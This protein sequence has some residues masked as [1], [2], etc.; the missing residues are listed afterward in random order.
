MPYCTARGT[1]LGPV[2]DNF[3]A[4]CHQM[5]RADLMLADLRD[6]K[7]QGTRRRSGRLRLYPTGRS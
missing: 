7:R 5:D 6:R 2:V 1:D 3:G 4:T